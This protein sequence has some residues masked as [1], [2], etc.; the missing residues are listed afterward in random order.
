MAL[1]LKKYYVITGGIHCVTGLRIGGSAENIEIGGLENTII[2]HPLTDEPYIPGSSLKG[3]LRSLLEYHDGRVTERGEPCGCG[4]CRICR[5]FGAHK[6]TKH[7]LG[8]TR[9]I[10]RDA[11][12]SDDSRKRLEQAREERG[13]MYAEVKTENVIDRRSGVAEYPRTQERVP[14]GV[15]FDFE[16]SLRIF[17]G[18][19]ETV[20]VQLIKD[21]LNLLQK[22]YL[23]SSGTRGYGKVAIAIREG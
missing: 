8:P 17:D 22:D 19:D 6:N 10:F 3:K 15:D 21:G 4:A 7:N 20:I 23:G 18:D 12:L 16:I 14:A 1:K 5:V 11:C 9:A 13:L 2:R